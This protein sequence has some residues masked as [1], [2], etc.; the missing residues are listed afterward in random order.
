MKPVAP[1]SA[2][3][4]AA[5]LAL[6]AAGC[7]S[8][9]A[10]RVA[11]LGTT[12]TRSRPPSR[13]STRDQALAYAR[14][15]RSHGVPLWPDPDADGAFDKSALTPQKLG[16]GTAQIGRAQRTCTAFLPTYSAAGQARVLAEALRFSRCMRA[17]GATNFP[18]PESNG[19]IRIPHAM[20]SS[21]AYLAALRFCLRRYGV[22]PPP[23]PAG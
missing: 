1:L 11:Q 6:A 5:C 13:G 21:P 23:S 20:E 9:P 4:L 8:S 3:L 12:A 15:I 14:C 16:V 10:G 22:P 2:L 7:G 19:A 18:D 17:H